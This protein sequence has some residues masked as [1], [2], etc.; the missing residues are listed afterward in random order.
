MN[1]RNP[2]KDSISLS[3]CGYGWNFKIDFPKDD[4]LKRYTQARMESIVYNG[5]PLTI[6]QFL[7]FTMAAYVHQGT[8]QILGIK[9]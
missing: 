8:A 1:Y 9:Q 7:V 5:T 2:N 6:R 4:L 3:L